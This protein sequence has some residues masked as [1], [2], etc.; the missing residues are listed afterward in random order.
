[1]N[2]FNGKTVLVIGA[3]G[4]IGEAVSVLF[5]KEGA[6]LILAGKSLDKLRKVQEKCKPFTS[7]SSIIKM[8]IT[9]RSSVRNAIKTSFNQEREINC[10]IH[11]A[12]IFSAYNFDEISVE[13]KKRVYAINLLGPYLVTEEVMKHWESK[14]Y[15][16][17]VIFLS[18]IAG[19][20]ALPNQREVY[21]FSKRMLIDLFRKYHAEFGK[22]INFNCVCPGPVRT[23]MLQW[24]CESV[25]A[26]K[27][28]SA[29]EVLQSLEQEGHRIMNADELAPYI[30]GLLNQKGILLA[31]SKGIKE[32][33][34]SDYNFDELEK[35]LEELRNT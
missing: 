3:S 11:A 34:I 9:S 19:L 17:S 18:S 14:S 24:M 32:R 23:T 30:V 5:S 26:R 13:E 16:K 31:P 8:D 27:N 35:T 1:M 4:G 12:G 28:T 21:A 29:Q 10:V 2:T 25:G 15:L 6:R 20:G 33:Q 22:K 7:F